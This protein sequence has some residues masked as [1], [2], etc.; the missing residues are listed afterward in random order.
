MASFAAA[1]P[2]TTRPARAGAAPSPATASS[3]SRRG[4]GVVVVRPTRGARR[5]A[6]ASAS[7]SGARSSGS[8]P[9]PA[10]GKKP[11]RRRVA[12][13]SAGG[14]ELETTRAAVATD[15]ADIVPALDDDDD[16]D[17]ASSRAASSSASS[18]SSS[19]TRSPVETSQ[20]IHLGAAA[21]AS[22][23]L[24]RLRDGL[25]GLVLDAGGGAV[26]PFRSGLFRLTVA[27]PRGADALE[28]LSRLPR[29]APALLPMYYMSP[30]TPP[31]SVRAERAGAG[32]ARGR[33]AADDDDDD[34][35]SFAASENAAAHAEPPGWRADP[36]GA[37]A[38]A[39]GACVWTSPDAFGA[40]QLASVRRWTH[41]C[42]PSDGGPRAYGCGRFDAARPGGADEEWAAFGGHYFALPL[43]EVVEGTRCCTVAVHVAWERSSGYDAGEDGTSIGGGGGGGGATAGD[44]AA[45]VAAAVDAVDAASEAHAPVRIRS[46][47][48]ANDDDDD[49]DKRTTET[50]SGGVARLPPGAARVLSRELRPDRSGWTDVVDGLLKSL[51]EGEAAAAAAAVQAARAAAEREAA[52][53]EA[54]APPSATA[55][56]TATAGSGPARTYVW[57]EEYAYKEE[58]DSYVDAFA[59]GD[60]IYGPGSS[61]G[62]GPG[63]QRRRDE[64]SVIRD[65]LLELGRS[66]GVEAPPASVMRDLEA[67][68]MAAGMGANATNSALAPGSDFNS[69]DWSDADDIGS[70]GLGWGATD[71]DPKSGGGASAAS[72]ERVADAMAAAEG[73]A[74][75]ADDVDDDALA[76]LRKVVLARRTTLALSDAIDALSLVSS[77]RAR[78]PDAYQF[79]LIHPSGAAFVGSTPER[80]FSS[81]DGH[82]ASEAVA[83]TRPRGADEGE[84][85]AL[86]YQMLLSPK[87]HEEFAIVREEVRRALGS[88]ADGGARGVNAE[89]EKGVLRHVS[90][91][92]LYARLGAKL[93]PGKDEADVLRALHPTPAVCGHPRRAA[94]RAIRASESFDRG[95]YA[96]PVGW[97]SRDAA[98]FAVAI[99]SALVSPSGVDVKLFAGVGV[100]AAA[101]SAAEW[102][103]LNL[104]TR[105]LEALLAQKPSLDAAVNANAAW[106]DV[107]IGEL[108]RGGVHVFCVAPGSRST[109]LA[110]AAEK[111]QTA[112]VVVCVDER[113]LGFYAL[114]YGKGRGRAA[115][116]ITS[117]GTA[118]ANLLPACVEAHESGAPL[119]LLTADRPPELR[120]TGANQTIDQVKIFEGFARYAV[121]LPP[122]GDGAPARVYA[123]AAAT[124]AR[125]L[126][127]DRPG[128]VHL[129]VQF[130]DPLGPVKSAWDPARDL[131]GLEGWERRAAPFVSGGASGASGG[132]TASHTTPF[133]W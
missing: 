123:T 49:D 36:R 7:A 73:E 55:T 16:D 18:S 92:H 45:A 59:S 38:A 126:H 98:E 54:A 100:V 41:T 58:Q 128:P 72:A 80:L 47:A 50:T 110:L 66:A 64:R 96:G 107:L 105:P 1:A 115:A 95:L 68:A 27:I 62:A 101:D 67:F 25:R 122:P 53:R 82:A 124:A 28:W 79:A 102:R 104:K 44:F 108:V 5:A 15:A 51:R 46:G 78:D 94:L 12:D 63:D 33:S 61:V 4:G 30:R 117:S 99:R 133:A 14:G 42:E 106:A 93:A 43:L 57:D 2:S 87:E 81:R 88:V 91:Q 70:I 74:T 9:A 48:N 112:R 120:D 85:A 89:L 132:E 37:V 76:P 52:E 22:D 21:S 103:E 75:E 114:G 10:R 56:A 86:A 31:P 118:V 129:N 83:G 17:D 65:K 19:R 113:S 34:D 29:D 125:H 90:V 32:G 13:P 109:P 39:G 26:P 60:G 24:R 71:V 119:L 77:L 69:G 84:D 23:A 131:R 116:V 130:R 3:S 6:S 111:H 20:H 121:D 127:G 11:R 40:T 35:D 97:V 8:N